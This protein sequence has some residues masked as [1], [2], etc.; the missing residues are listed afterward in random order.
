MVHRL[1]K[2]DF[3]TE[4]DK[5]DSTPLMKLLVVGRIIHIRIHRNRDSVRVR[6]QG[7]TRLQMEFRQ[8]SSPPY[9]SD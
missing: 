2:K 3:S 7:G 4:T 9:S 8:L 1:R 5:T 6:G